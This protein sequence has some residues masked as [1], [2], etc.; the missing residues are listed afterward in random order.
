[1]ETYD[2]V[3]SLHNGALDTSKDSPI[4][5]PVGASKNL[6]DLCLKANDESL[7]TNLESP[8]GWKR[9]NVKVPV[10]PETVGIIDE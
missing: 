4:Q 2:L 6:T 3:V 9:V 1:M 7:A 10:G 5:C 8:C